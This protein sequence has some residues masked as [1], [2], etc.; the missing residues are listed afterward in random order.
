NQAGLR[1]QDNTIIQQ[2]Q[3]VFAQCCP[4]LSQIDNEISRI[5]QRCS[6]ECSMRGD[7]LAMR[8]T[9]PAQELPGQCGVFGGDTQSSRL[10]G[11]IITCQV[12]ENSGGAHIKS[13]S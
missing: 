7:Y 3:V 4:C 10:V 11:G 13:G 2:L 6:F 9:V 12:P 5:G 8:N 1:A